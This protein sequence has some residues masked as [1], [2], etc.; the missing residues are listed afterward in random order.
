MA[1]MLDAVIEFFTQDNWP[2][3][4]IK[5]QPI[6]RLGF[7]GNHGQWNC[8]AQVREDQQQFVF[9][10]LFP[11]NVPEDKRLAV[12][13]FTSRANYGIMIGNLEIDMDDGQV[14]YKTSI[15]VEED[16]LSAALIKQLV[17]TNVLT[18]DRYLPGIMSVIYGNVSPREAVAQVEG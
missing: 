12:S 14:R 18:M 15:D 9:Y 13:E 3:S 6:L 5:D 17:Y 16:R 1:E 2:F 11:V 10:S 4:Q 8:F 7:Q